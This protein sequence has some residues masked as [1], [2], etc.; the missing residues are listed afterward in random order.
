MTQQSRARRFVEAPPDPGRFHQDAP[1][2]KRSPGQAFVAA[3]ALLL[4]VVG[5]PVALWVLSG[6]PPFPDGWPT[7][8]DLTAPIG[9]ETLLTV[10]RAVVW[11]AWLHFVVC[12]IAEFSS[13]ARGRGVPTAIPLGGGSQRLARILVSALLLTGIAV[14]QAAAATGAGGGHLEPG[15]QV[16]IGAKATTTTTTVAETEAAENQRVGPVQFDGVHNK[17]NPLAGKKIYTVKAPVG[18]KHDNLWDIAEAHL[19][20]G[21]RYKEIYELNKERVQPDGQ[22]LH[23]AKL[24]MPG[25]DLIMPE[26]A[27]GVERVPVHQ[28]TPA[29]VSKGEDT[30][31]T[32][33]P[34]DHKEGPAVATPVS[35]EAGS[36]NTGPVAGPTGDGGGGA[37]T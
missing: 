15:S 35:G 36:V 8:E 14:G 34:D 33:T 12:V 25:W 24:I 37:S 6:P 5:V 32:A 26:D 1:P 31:K 29:P 21:R 20:D 10:L 11:I 3:I 30:A 23:L 17:A 13:A 4:L 22:H 28:A 27:V 18:H 16:S 7:R 19:G 9:V 2:E